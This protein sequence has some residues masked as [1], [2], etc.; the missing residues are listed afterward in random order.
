VPL[1]P[2]RGESCHHQ[3]R[4]Y[5]PDSTFHIRRPTSGSTLKIK[6]PIPLN[7]GRAQDEHGARNEAFVA[8]QIRTQT[9]GPEPPTWHLFPEASFRLAGKRLSPSKMAQLF[10]GPP[11]MPRSRRNDRIPLQNRASRLDL[12]KGPIGRSRSSAKCKDI[13]PQATLPRKGL[14]SACKAAPGRVRNRP[15]R[16]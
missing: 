10:D 4:C 1:E 2:G 5:L 3:C 9:S 12:R 6:V 16:S 11:Q 15:T 13:P 8:T 14:A 7:G